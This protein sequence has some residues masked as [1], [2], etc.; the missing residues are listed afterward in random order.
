MESTKAGCA[1]VHGTDPAAPAV[2]PWIAAATDV[3]H[4]HPDDD[5]C[6]I[7]A[8]LDAESA[9]VIVDA[10]PLERRLIFAVWAWP[11]LAVGGRLVL[12]AAESA[13][14]IGITF[15]VALQVF[16]ELDRM[17]I[18]PDGADVAVLRKCR[19]KPYVNWNRVE[20]RASWQVG[21]DD[22]AATLERLGAA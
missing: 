3:R 20:D 12:V 9:D 6:G 11:R 17:D 15:A 16:R 19:P 1:L 2:R 21:D 8:G 5:P 10:G 18:T 22:L 4:L 13:R 7:P 14:A